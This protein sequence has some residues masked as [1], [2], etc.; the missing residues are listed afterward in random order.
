MVTNARFAKSHN[1]YDSV[2]SPH[3]FPR[4]PLF[5]NPPI[6]HVYSPKER[7]ID[8]DGDGDLTAF[9]LLLTE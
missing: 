9:E 4:L 5:T 2:I 7:L 8:T 3:N 6:H 1:A